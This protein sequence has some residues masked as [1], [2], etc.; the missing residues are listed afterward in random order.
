MSIGTNP[1]KPHLSPKLWLFGPSDLCLSRDIPQPSELGETQ[2]LSGKRNTK[3]HNVCRRSSYRAAGKSQI[4]I[5]FII[6]RPCAILR[7]YHFHVDSLIDL[8]KSRRSIYKLGKNSPVPDS[9]IEEI[10]T[11]A[12]LHVP[13]SFNTQSTR[14]V[15]LLHEEHERLWDIVIDTL[16]PLVTNGTIPEEMWKNGT[17]PKLQG[18]K[19]AFGTA[20]LLVTDIVFQKCTRSYFTKILPTLS[21][22]RPSSAYT[23]II[24]SRGLYMRTP[25]TSIMVSDFSLSKLQP[26]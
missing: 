1:I 17:L 20:H 24:S 16:A 26:R 15:L 2:I 9:R 23:K 6:R 14:L 10:L 12:I 13:S 3:S 25:C 4:H 22:T 11:S 8:A 19:A 5:A 18:L 21:P 7:M